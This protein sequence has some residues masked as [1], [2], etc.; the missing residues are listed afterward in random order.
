MQGVDRAALSDDLVEGVTAWASTETPQ[1]GEFVGK[2]VIVLRSIQPA[3]L[4]GPETIFGLSGLVFVLGRLPANGFPLTRA[5]R[6]CS[7]PFGFVESTPVPH[8]VAAAVTVAVTVAVAVVVTVAVAV[9]V[10]VTVTVAFGW[11]VS[12]SPP[13]RP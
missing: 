3:V 4:V 10:F 12:Q 13:A 9:A 5:A 11:V 7:M 1:T 6:N 2:P 8:A